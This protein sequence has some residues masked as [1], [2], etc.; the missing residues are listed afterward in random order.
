MARSLGE[1][2]SRQQ[3]VIDCD[4]S[5]IRAAFEDSKAWGLSASFDIHGCNARAIRDKETINLFTTEL[6]EYIDMEPYGDCIVVHFGRD[7]RVAGIS[8][9]QLI[10]TSN[11]SAHF[12]NE[13]NRAYPD[14]FSCKYYNELKAGWFIM[15]YFGGSS[16]SLTITLR[17]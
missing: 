17:E 11:L 5:A 6:C 8:M 7:P 16:F 14:I 13:T 3:H 15:R 1:F 9:L 10:Q 12:A 4:D 2:D